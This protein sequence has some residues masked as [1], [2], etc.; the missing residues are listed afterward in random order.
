MGKDPAFLFYSSDFLTGTMFMTDEQVGKYIRLLCAQHQTGHL[1]EEHMLNICKTYDKHIFDK[2]KKDD[3][4]SYYQPRLEDEINKRKLYSQSRSENRKGKSKSKKDMK[5]ISSS[6]VKHMENE[7]EIINININDNKSSNKK[8][9]KE[10]LLER[11]EEFWAL[12]PKK[13]GKGKAK[14][15]WLKKKPSETLHQKIL[16]AVESAKNSREW[17]S[18]NGK[19]IPHPTTWL[20]QER[21][22]DELTTGNDHLETNNP[23]LKRLHA[24]GEL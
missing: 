7:N 23:F 12:Y 11:F 24:G 1:T 16:A 9:A 21:W 15:S 10:I 5:N 13:V 18:E 8:G 22:D 14:E 17:L 19:Y 4:G 20:N 3:R 2:F 6:Y